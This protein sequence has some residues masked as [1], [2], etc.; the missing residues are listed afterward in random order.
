MIKIENL[1]KEYNGRR[2]LDEVNLEFPNTGFVVIKGKNGSGKSTLMNMLSTLDVPNSGTIKYDDFEVTKKKDDVLSKFREENIGLIFQDNNLFDEMS[3]RDNINIV[4]ENAKFDEVVDTLNLRELLDKKAKLLSGGEQQRVA[5][6]R[7]VLKGAKVIFADEP[8]SAIDSDTKGSIL[9]L[10]KEISKDRLVI[11]ITHDIN[12]IEE[13]SDMVITLDDGK[14]KDVKKK[15][16]EEKTNKGVQ[17]RNKFDIRKFTFTSLFKNKKSIKRI[18]TLILLSVMFIFITIGIIKLDYNQMMIDTMNGEKDNYVYF[19]EPYNNG[20]E[21][22]IDKFK[23]IKVSN[24]ELKYGKIINGDNGKPIYFDFNTGDIYDNSI[25]IFLGLEELDE[26]SFGKKPTKDNEIV[27][28]SHFADLIIENGIVS[29]NGMYK[30]SSY[31]E[32]INDRREIVLEK[33]NVIISGITDKYFRNGSFQN[34]SIR[35]DMITNIGRNVYVTDEFFD[36][37]NEEII[38]FDSNI[39]ISNEDILTPM[40]GHSCDY[41]KIFVEPVALKDGMVVAELKDDEVIL[42]KTLLDMIGYKEDNVPQEGTVYIKKGEE[43]DKVAFKIVGISQDDKSYYSKDLVKDYLAKRVSIGSVYMWEDDK[44]VLKKLFDNYFNQENRTYVLRTNYSG[45][46]WSIE[47]SLELIIILFVI[48]SGALI[49][50]TIINLINFVLS[51]VNEHK[52]EVAILKSLGVNDRLIHKAFTIEVLTVLVR[53]FVFGFVTFLVVRIIINIAASKLFLFKVNIVPINILL[54]ICVLIGL[55][56]VG[57][58]VNMLVFGKIRK[59]SPQILMKNI[60]I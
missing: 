12:N 31:E 22:S 55:I 29:V 25:P 58:V 7:A 21:Y 33:H 40:L 53:A 3:V 8:T 54:I 18:T 19:N 48:I 57:L 42:N 24:N 51:I 56:I 47:G 2:V 10:L 34:D 28:N 15:I 4:G 27:I 11:M 49:I 38:S 35:K 41:G 26:V 46:Y 16:L 45:L 6:A 13:Y 43:V 39:C 36:L 50:I 37:Y 14:V 60:K 32:I 44:K 9:G 52:K 59:T 30:P 1:V 5:I 17:Y 20:I 23:E